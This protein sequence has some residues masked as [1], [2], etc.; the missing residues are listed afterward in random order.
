MNGFHEFSYSFKVLIEYTICIAHVS[1]CTPSHVSCPNVSIIHYLC[2][3]FNSPLRPPVKNILTTKTC[4]AAIPTISPLSTNEKFQILFSVLLTV[5]KFRFS[6]VRK[7]FWL[8]AMLHMPVEIFEMLSSRT[9]V[10]SEVVPCFEGMTAWRAS[11]STVISKSM[12]LSAKV[13]MVL[14]KQKRYSPLVV[15]V[16]T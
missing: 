3:L 14:S 9:E 8:L 1:I 11:F 13:L 2:C 6:R 12:T 5:E 10:C 4:S 15:A 16:K 7:Y